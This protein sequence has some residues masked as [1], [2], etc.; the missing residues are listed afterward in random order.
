MRP[1]LTL[2]AILTLL[3]TF[4]GGYALADCIQDPVSYWTLDESGSPYANDILAAS[5]GNCTS[6]SCPT[7]TTDGDYIVTGAQSFDGVDDGIN[8]ANVDS[9][10]FDIQAANSSFSIGVWFKRTADAAWNGD[11]NEVL[12]G[13][14]VTSTTHFW[15]GLQNQTGYA[16]FRLWD[17]DMFGSHDA[18]MIIGTTNI[19]DGQWHHIL[20]V[21]DS[22]TEKNILY[23]DG[24]QEGELTVT[25][26]GTFSA[27][28]PMTFGSMDNQYFFNGNIDELYYFN[29]AVTPT[30]AGL[31][32]DAGLAGNSICSGNHSPVI[33][34]AA[35]T[36]ASV[37]AEY[38]YKPAATD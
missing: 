38:S 15:V 26:S 36:T 16:A 21:R 30:N 27:D 24:V 32:Y 2:I 11:Q 22:E 4:W 3:G 14:Y 37:G 8:V 13:R 6:P 17:A 19:A 25:Y 1:T 29:E 18:G 23:V 33:T 10:V 9:A 5:P 35:P 12:V 34:S 20:A 7:L 31:I 28:E